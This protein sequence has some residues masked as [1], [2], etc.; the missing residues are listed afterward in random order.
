MSRRP[1][2]DLAHSNRAGAQPRAVPRPAPGKRTRTAR[3]YG[4]ATA[5]PGAA[6]SPS[7]EANGARPLNVDYGMLP[8]EVY[9]MEQAEG[10]VSHASTST[11]QALPEDLADRFSA[12]LGA[13]LSRVRIHTGAESA[14]AARAVGAK[15]YAVGQ[16]VHFA[17]GQY[18]PASAAGQHL[19][20][21]E[22]A[23][24]VQQSG[25]SEVRQN[26]LEVS[27]PGDAH[28]AEADRAAEAMV[29]GDATSITT[30]APAGVSRFWD[31]VSELIFGEEEV[32]TKTPYQ[33]GPAPSAQP[34]AQPS[35]D[36]EVQRAEQDLAISQSQLAAA[37]QADTAARANLDQSKAALDA[38]RE[39]HAQ[40]ASDGA[41]GVPGT[42]AN[43]RLAAAEQ[44]T[45]AAENA[46]E[47]ATR[48][49][50]RC[51]QELRDA[52]AN[53]RVMYANLEEARRNAAARVPAG[54]QA[55]APAGGEES[56]SF[57]DSLW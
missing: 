37:Q 27:S 26:K 21:H 45:R 53:E 56:G 42:A 41:A 40:A 18:D 34:S 14:S 30:S 36:V 15:A 46:L 28:E 23:H 3:A 29:A 32:A 1:H 51:A 25:G 10:A 31:E 44:R 12:S 19:L 8:P 33:P 4:D 38:A 48:T 6:A 16:D 17:A 35:Y 39:Q 9:V 55:G 54:G 5:A 2:S 49:A 50:E 57:W 22:V 20:A 7:A 13:D 47:V 24:T 43:G 11:G 52:E